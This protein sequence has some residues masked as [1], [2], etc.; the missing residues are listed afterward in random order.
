VQLEKDL[1]QQSA[2]RARPFGGTRSTVVPAPP[3]APARAL[4]DAKAAETI[5][6]RA[7]GDQSTVPFYFREFAGGGFGKGVKTASSYRET[8]YWNPLL[9]TDSNGRM[10]FE[11]D[12]P[13]VEATYRVLV[14]GHEEGRLGSDSKVI[15]VSPNR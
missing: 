9:L 6:P 14:E 8:L 4:A 10:A 7:A 15:T 12:L 13:Q 5:A 3:A 11:F 2:T 1:P